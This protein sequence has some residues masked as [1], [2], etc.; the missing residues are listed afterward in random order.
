MTRQMERWG[1]GEVVWWFLWELV[2]DLAGVQEFFC[3]ADHFI[4]FQA[5]ILQ[6]A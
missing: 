2:R 1:G 4:I 3:N 5:V 6:L